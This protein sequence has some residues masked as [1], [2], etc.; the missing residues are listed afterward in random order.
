MIR[1]RAKSQQVRQ[2]FLNGG[3]Q[4]IISRVANGA[5]QASVALNAPSGDTVLSLRSRDAGLRANQLRVRIDYNTS[6]PSELQSRDL[7]RGLRR[8]RPAAS[9]RVRELQRSQPLAQL[10]PLCPNHPRSTVTAGDCKFQHAKHYGRGSEG[11]SPRHDQRLFGKLWYLCRCCRGRVGAAAGGAELRDGWPV[12][13]ARRRRKFFPTLTISVNAGDTSLDSL[14]TNINTMLA[15]HT[16]V[17]V[18]VP[19]PTNQP[20]TIQAVDAGHD[21]AGHD[22]VIEPAAVRHFCCDGAWGV[23]GE[24]SR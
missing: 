8:E 22:I 5:Q 24:A 14:L 7:P 21:D 17:T 20:L 3:E 18:A 6:A 23:A 16:Q 1:A 11:G 4:A 9:D 19:T 10:C 2:F 12:P 13:A 15:P